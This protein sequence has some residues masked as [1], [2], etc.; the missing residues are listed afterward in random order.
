MGQLWIARTHPRSIVWM[1]KTVSNFNRGLRLELCNSTDA[2]RYERIGERAVAGR[3]RTSYNMQQMPT[4]TR[5]RDRCRVDRGV[6]R[7]KH[8]ESPN[9]PADQEAIVEGLTRV[10]WHSGPEGD[11][12]L[13]QA[14]KVD[15][16][17]ANTVLEAA[18]S[19]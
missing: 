9:H 4:P 6:R 17:S 1:S 2:S 14:L 18:K 16:R 13:T 12:C 3:H 19:R 10:E 15:A 7:G 5:C 8:P 11:P